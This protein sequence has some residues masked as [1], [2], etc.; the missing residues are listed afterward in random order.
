MN[1]QYESEVADRLMILGRNMI[2]SGK[3]SIGD[4]CIDGA[5][6]IK[7]L[8]LERDQLQKALQKCIRANRLPEVASIAL[9]ALQNKHHK[10]E[11]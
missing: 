9:T 5:R 3:E 8:L 6:Q 4:Q 11:D 10:T 2:H 7:E 1:E